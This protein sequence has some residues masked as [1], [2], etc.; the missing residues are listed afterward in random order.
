MPPPCCLGGAEA[1]GGWL[2][3]APMGRAIDAVGAAVM[4]VSGR[5]PVAMRVTVTVPEVLSSPAPKMMLVSGET[6][7]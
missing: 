7:E 6:A 1:G 3:W 4:G 5:M 2:G